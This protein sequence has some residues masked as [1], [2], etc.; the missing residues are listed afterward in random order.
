MPFMNLVLGA[1]EGTSGG[2]GLRED[3]VLLTVKRA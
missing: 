2:E 3:V 1:L